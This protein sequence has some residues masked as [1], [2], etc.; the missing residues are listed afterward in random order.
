LAE[1]HPGTGIAL[2]M[3]MKRNATIVL[4][5]VICACAPGS[6]QA[7]RFRT[8]KKAVAAAGGGLVG[9]VL[10]GA[11]GALSNAWHTISPMPRPAEKRG[12]TFTH[13]F[14]GNQLHTE[15]TVRRAG[16]PGLFKTALWGGAAVALMAAGVSLDHIPV[17]SQLAGE[18]AEQLPN[19]STA[20]QAFVTGSALHG[21]K[22][23]LIG[24][25]F[26][27][28]KLGALPGMVVGGIV[29]GKRAADEVR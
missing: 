10:G 12:L 9:S 18:V 15:M 22:N 25:G 17:V 6:G 1:A 4:V 29:L 3:V 7:A 8:V 16:L 27:P 23:V 20:T 5:V 13:R 21:L 24:H 14:N 2:L 19:A 26:R 11:S 28:W